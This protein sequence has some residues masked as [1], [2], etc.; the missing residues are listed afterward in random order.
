MKRIR[1][2]RDCLPWIQDGSKTTTFRKT[3]RVGLYKI[4]EGVW[5]NVRDLGIVIQ[6]SPIMLTTATDVIQNHYAT[7]GP[8]TSPAAFEAWLRRVGLTLPERGWLN[9]IKH[10]HT[11]TAVP[12][13]AK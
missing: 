12:L 7:E 6:C 3:V 13:E 11:D 8:F 9:S 10:L 2:R 5:Y 1:F 4:V